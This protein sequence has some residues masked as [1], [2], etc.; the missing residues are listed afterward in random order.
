MCKFSTH[1]FDFLLKFKRS[2]FN[3]TA[4]D[5]YRDDM[6]KNAPDS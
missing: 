3:M 6:N 1:V 4:R 5:N 2:I